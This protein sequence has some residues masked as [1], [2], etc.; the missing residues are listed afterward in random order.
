MA[1]RAAMKAVIALHCLYS[2]KMAVR[3]GALSPLV[4]RASKIGVGR[5]GGSGILIFNEYRWWSAI[6][7]FNVFAPVVAILTT[8]SVSTRNPGRSE[9]SHGPRLIAIYRRTDSRQM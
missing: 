2:L 4:I 9:L 5:P 7:A 6:T 8:I 3:A 1:C